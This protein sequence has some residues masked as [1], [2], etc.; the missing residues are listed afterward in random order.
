VFTNADDNKLD[1]MYCRDEFKVAQN[2]VITVEGRGRSDDF[3][4]KN[5][6]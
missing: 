3:E 2:W 5:E 4:L 6:R 1:L